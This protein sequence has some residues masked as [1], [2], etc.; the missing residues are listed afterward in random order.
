MMTP[1]TI[2]QVIRH[3]RTEKVLAEVD[4]PY[5]IDASTAA[6]RRQS[7]VEAVQTAGMAPFHF[8]RGVEEIAEP[9]RA[10]IL[11][12]EEARSLA[13]HLRD[14][15]G[16]VSKE[17]NLLAGCGATVLV[18]WLPE[19][20]SDLSA[21][22][23]GASSIAKLRCRDEEHLAATGAMVQNLLLLLAAQ[24][25][26]TYW[27]SGGKLGSTEVF[28]LLGIGSDERLIAAVFIEYPEMMDQPATRKA[29]SQRPKRSDR[30]IREVASKVQEL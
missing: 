5:P 26:G 9:W 20:P 6:V 19:C 7:V 27:S 22:T 25:M 28:D 18:T 30:W 3:R 4:S 15:M 1:S 24:A 2:Q 23:P 14:A 10:L 16:V 11:G 8:D 17:P 29:G 12:H 21:V 13:R